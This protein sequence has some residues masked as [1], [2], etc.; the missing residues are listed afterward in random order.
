MRLRELVETSRSVGEVSGRLE[1]IGRL[2]ALLERLA[3]EEIE[4]ATSF[5]SGSPRQGRIGVGWALISDARASSVPFDAFNVVP[6]SGEAAAQAQAAIAA[7][8]WSCAVG[9]EL[10]AAS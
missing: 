4:I 10:A 1:K 6:R 9:C 7:G 8:G 2:A 5:L 3:P